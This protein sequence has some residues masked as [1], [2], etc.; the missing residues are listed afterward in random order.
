MLELSRISRQT[1][2]AKMEYQRLRAEELE[3]I[4]SLMKDE[5]EESQAHVTKADLQIGSLRNSLHDAGV[6]VIGDKGR[7][8]AKKANGYSRV[9]PIHGHHEVDDSGGSYDSSVSS[10]CNGSGDDDDKLQAASEQSYYS[11]AVVPSFN[12]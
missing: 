8:G 12:P 4:T 2:A 3:L 9:F 6:A 1:F 5:M 11:R 10:G 7:K